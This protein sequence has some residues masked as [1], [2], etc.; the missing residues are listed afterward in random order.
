ML[1][2]KNAALEATIESLSADASRYRNQY[3][4]MAMEVDVLREHRKQAVLE[5]QEA[6]KELKMLQRQLQKERREAHQTQEHLQQQIQALHSISL[7]QSK[8]NTSNTSNGLAA[9]SNQN[10]PTTA[11]VDA[12]HER[13]EA[14]IHSS[15]DE[16][17]EALH[18]VREMN[19]RLRN[20]LEQSNARCRH[21][22]DARTRETS[23]WEN[24]Q[25]ALEVH[26]RQLQFQLQTLKAE[27]EEERALMES[28]QVMIQTYKVCG[29]SHV[30]IYIY[31]DGL[32]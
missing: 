22:H 11:V 26:C 19:E 18:K 2:E 27:Q 13:P 28:L 31:M 32:R 24:Q 5:V 16:V 14:P 8:S 23:M 21:A 30:Y 6:H 12:E 20:E 1:L 17:T 3:R 10:E 25:K 15:E 29:C 7:Y 4:E 9:S